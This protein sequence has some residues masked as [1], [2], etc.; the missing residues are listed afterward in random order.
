VVTVKLPERPKEGEV[1]ERR[2]TFVAGLFCL[3]YGA[4]RMKAG[5]LGWRN[6]QAQP[7]TVHIVFALGV[8][9]IVIGILDV[10]VWTPQRRRESKREH[11]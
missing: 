10:L 6:F 11:R 2:A 9:L 5:Q 4:V 1:R 7:V 8:I 3:V